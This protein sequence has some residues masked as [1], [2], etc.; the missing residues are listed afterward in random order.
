L[1]VIST[2]P[3]GTA[4]SRGHGPAVN[5]FPTTDRGP[6][7]A[8]RCRAK[9]RGPWPSPVEDLRRRVLQRHVGGRRSSGCPDAPVAI[10]WEKAP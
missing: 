9:A 4:G 1:S 5:K 10:A 8:N 2:P 7:E 3:V 6:A